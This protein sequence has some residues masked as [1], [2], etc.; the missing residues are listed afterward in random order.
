MRLNLEA[1][2]GR[3]LMS[4]TAVGVIAAPA[5]ADSAAR[6]TDGAASAAVIIGDIGKGDA[7]AVTRYQGPGDTNMYWG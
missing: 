2:D 1:L 4:A 5:G 6:V 3:D 7:G